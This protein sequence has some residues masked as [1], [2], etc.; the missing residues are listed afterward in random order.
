MTTL[1]DIGED[2]VDL[3]YANLREARYVGERDMREV[4]DAMWAMYEPYADP[5]FRDGFAQDP[6][7]RFWEMQL[8]CWLIEAGKTLLP[9]ARR[10]REGGQPD[11][12][13]LDAGRRIWIEAIAPSHGAPGPDRVCG[14]APVNEGGGFSPAPT[15]QAQLRMTS[16]LWTKTKA[17]NKYL[18]EG[19]IGIDDV[20]LIAIGAGRFG[21]YV[22]EDPVPL[23]M[24]A[25]FPIGDEFVSIDNETGAVV[26]QG[27][28]MS[29]E[30]ERQGSV[31]SRTAFLDEGFSPISGVIWSRIGIG[32]MSRAQRPLTLVHNPLAAIVMPSS[33][34][35]WDRE[36]VTTRQVDHWIATDILAFDPA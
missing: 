27:F 1:W 25:V 30:I 32:N 28:R 20:R 15:R 4:L 5:D 35:V 11:I 17:V 7:A 6:D 24:S 31:V 33:W 16:A 3:G 21:A 34:G 2:K 36:F 9:V 10:H 26:D 13:V 18:R 14:P 12:C 23:I 22:S 29:L 19:V 8:G